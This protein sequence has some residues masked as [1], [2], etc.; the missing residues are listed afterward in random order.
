MIDRVSLKKEAR[1][2]LKGKYGTPVLAGIILFLVFVLFYGTAFVTGMINTE[3]TESIPKGFW[4]YFAMS[5]LITIFIPVYIF[6]YTKIII[7]IKKTGKKAS[8]KD[9]TDNFN[10]IGKALG[11]YWYKL[12]WIYIWM[13]AFIPLMIIVMVIVIFVFKDSL[14]G[15]GTQ[16]NPGTIAMFIG[17][18]MLVYIPMI[19]ILIYKSIQYSLGLYI[20][21]ENPDREVIE[22]FNNGKKLTKGY[23]D[24]IFIM[25]L[26]FIGWYFLSLFTLGIAGFFFAPYYIMSQYNLYE[27]IRD[28]KIRIS[29]NASTT[30]LPSSSNSSN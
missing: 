25:S 1:K 26:S 23:K 29:Q 15:L 9:F 4:A 17:I 27:A 18:F 11:I 2:S 6:A 22:S 19:V 24:Q 12:L 28:E 21:A 30:D 16:N 5:I 13:L 7:Q 8:F 3:Q 14:T 20:L 10:F